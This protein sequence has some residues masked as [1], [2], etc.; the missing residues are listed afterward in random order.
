[1]RGPEYCQGKEGKEGGRKRGRE[2]ERE[3][4]R[5][6]SCRL[7]VICHNLSFLC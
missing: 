4:G 1:M 5:E 6:K 7:G 3:E 2:K